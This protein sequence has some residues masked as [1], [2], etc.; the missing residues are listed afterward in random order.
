MKQAVAE[1]LEP[2]I[3]EKRKLWNDSVF[4]FDTNV[5]L[6][7]YRFSKNTRTALIDSIEKKQSNVWIPHQVAQE[8]MRNRY[9]VIFESVQ[10][11]ES[12]K[13]EAETFIKKCARELRKKDTDDE[14][15][16]L[17]TQVN[18][19][20]LKEQEKDLLISNPLDD[21]LLDQLMN[22]FDGRVGR[23]YTD[24]EIAQIKEE[25][26]ERYEK[27]IPPGY[28]DAKKGNEVDDNNM[29]GDLIVWKQIIEYSKEN[30]KDIIFVVNDQ[31]EDWW[32]IVLGRTIGP[33]IELRK[34]FYTQ[35]SHKFHM[36]TMESF[37]QYCG[38]EDGKNVEESVINELN[39]IGKEKNRKTKIDK[40]HKNTN[41]KDIIK[42]IENLQ[43]RIDDKQTLIDFLENRTD[44]ESLTESLESKVARLNWGLDILEKRKNKLLGELNGD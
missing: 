8:F 7:L 21:V 10:R 29:Y 17:K 32:N 19:W 24:E 38:D 22:L 18:D 26:K 37:I 28:K 35:T 42:Q 36:Y 15:V 5:L 20:I 14:I 3:E 23:R 25:G 31:K 11:Y 41:D 40:S 13:N 27:K 9:E 2:T 43:K 16:S 34:E 39:R 33:R 30:D 4:V 6:N 44:Y 1:Y 12:L